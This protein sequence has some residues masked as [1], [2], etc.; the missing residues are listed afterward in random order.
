MW[1]TLKIFLAQ[2]ILIGMILPVH[3]QGDRLQ[4]TAIQVKPGQGVAVAAAYDPKVPGP[5][6][7]VLLD[8]SDQF[9]AWNSELPT[10]WKP[11]RVAELELVVRLDRERKSLETVQ[12]QG[13][14]P[15]TSFKYDLDIQVLEARTGRLLD[16][17]VLRGSEPRRFPKKAPVHQ[18][19]LDGLPVVYLE[20]EE[21]LR[22]FVKPL[23]PPPDMR[24]VR[25]EPGIFTMGSPS[26]DKD[27]GVD[28]NRHQ[29]TL[30]R[31]FWMQA[32][33]VT[34]WQWRWVMGSN[35]SRFRGDNRPVEM[36]SWDD[37]QEFIRRLNR[38]DPG[39]NYRL[40]TE[41]EWEYACRAGSGDGMY[42]ERD[43]IAW[44]WENAG[45]KS[46]PTGRLKPNAWG[47]YDMIGNVWEWCA[48]R[49]GQ[50]PVRPV[51]DPIGPKRGKERVRRGG[52][53]YG[54]SYYCR[55]T[56]RSSYE[57]VV[58]RDDT[59]FRLVRQ[60]AAD[61]DA[62]RAAETE[63]RLKQ[64]QL[65]ETRKRE[66][67]RQ[68]EAETARKWEQQRRAQAEEAKQQASETEN[69]R[70]RWQAEIAQMVLEDR[71]V[72]D[73][74]GL[75]FTWIPAGSF[76]M[77]SPGVEPGRNA[78]EIQHPVTLT[79]GF[80]MQTTEVT[81]AQWKA[82]MGDYSADF[83]GD[84]FPAADVSWDDCQEFIRR[85]NETDPG[86]NYRLPTEAEWEHACRAAATTVYY[87]GT[88][89]D[90]KEA[91][92]ERDRISTTPVGS[93]PPNALG[94]FDM[95][96]NVSEWCADWYGPYPTEAVTDPTGPSSGS[97]RVSRGGCWQD[98]WWYCRSASRNAYY[99]DF[100]YSGQGFRLIRDR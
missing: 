10:D 3:G 9:H 33:E 85:L 78:D 88:R 15:I 55:A 37:C 62:A 19:S 92:F 80:W 84:R 26:S 2:L 86:K 71:A 82:V 69:T 7:L 28:E 73:K 25:I 43:T 45:G 96:G 70:L 36:V 54:V 16:S 46:H 76:L 31:G 21:A 64:N 38:Q 90:V 63:K 72:A 81:Q 1:N 93:Y 89:L 30:T 50:Y 24:F 48:D 32:T 65:E 58:Y 56:A 22:Q 6:R 14:P 75:T 61:L 79:R 67:Q 91:N 12:Y 17:F 47:L 44:C 74:L 98:R 51:T 20:L 100:R 97:K 4:E 39:K 18:I 42:G 11:D 53:W 52:G 60:D 59:G 5:H 49:Y 68:A 23:E 66:E 99:P 35:P 34:Q 40:P 94:L 57:P 13:G 87:C 95:A 27:R 8:A 77:G 29:V 41:A 83:Q